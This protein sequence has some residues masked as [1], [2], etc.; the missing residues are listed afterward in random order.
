MTSSD[1][2]ARSRELSERLGF[3]VV[4]R[5]GWIVRRSRGGPPITNELVQRL[6]DQADLEDA[7]LEPPPVHSV[8]ETNK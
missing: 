8:G 5:N 2:E 3:P 1:D 4:Y 7:G 6:L